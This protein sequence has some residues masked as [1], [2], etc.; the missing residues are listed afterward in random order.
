M[1]RAALAD[2]AAPNAFT[3]KRFPGIDQFRIWAALM[4]VAI[5]TAP[6]SSIDP[7]A[8]LLITYC[9]GR[10]GVPFF[11][12]VTGYFV[13]GPLFA[14]SPGKCEGR[15]APSV[16]IRRYLQ[17]LT[18]LYGLSSL[19][20]LPVA[21]YAG[22]GQ[23]WR[24]PAALLRMILFDGC[25]YHLWYLPA[26]ILGVIILFFLRRLRPKALLALTSVLYLI[27][28]GGDSYYGLILRIPAAE[29][30]YQFLFSI[31][32]YTRNGIFFAPLFLA[33]GAILAERN[34]KIRSRKGGNPP[35][36]NS[37]R[38]NP[39]GLGICLLFSLCLMAGEGLVTYRLG[40]QRH[41]SMYLFLAPS[42]Y[43]LFSW[44]LT[45]RGKVRPGLSSL[46]LWI[47][48]IHPFCILVVRLLAKMCGLTWLLVESSPV[49][50]L[51]VSFLSLLAS[52]G[53][54]ALLSRV[55]KTWGEH[56]QRRLPS[57]DK[58]ES[59]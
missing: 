29:T 47:Y 53:G 3:G 14:A 17:K 56:L 38:Q 45:L 2:S 44:L 12:M 25:F 28:L 13:L 24:T 26:A 34:E 11:F 49:H 8:D 19:F 57:K 6:L 32:S 54:R 37:N 1:S 50:F 52:L 55:R 5:H 51:A 43:F 41:N 21:L 15:K 40:L 23:D 36:P 10:V 33:M 20:Y 7:T 46:A 59:L 4:V 48:L 35:G 58:E 18:V 31:S 42:M 30:F 22:H 39:R 16:S 9:L 27:G